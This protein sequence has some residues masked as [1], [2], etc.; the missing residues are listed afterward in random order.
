MR[1][2]IAYLGLI[3]LSSVFLWIFAQIWI[4]ETIFVYENSLPIR[5]MET[6]FLMA[7][8]S[9]GIERFIYECRRR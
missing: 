9:L 7:L 4:Y 3:V 5:I 1:A 8:L 6:L 2:V